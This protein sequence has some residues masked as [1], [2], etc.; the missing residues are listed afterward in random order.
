VA[1]RTDP[2]IGWALAALGLSIVGGF[3]LRAPALLGSLPSGAGARLA[4]E[5]VVTGALGASILLSFMSAV[6]IITGSGALGGLAL[7][8]GTCILGIAYVLAVFVPMF[9]ADVTKDRPVPDDLACRRLAPVVSWWV[10]DE[11]AFDRD[12]ARLEPGA[13]TRLA[14]RR[15]QEIEAW[16]ERFRLLELPERLH[17]PAQTVDAAVTALL[18]AWEAQRFSP[19]GTSTAAVA[20]ERTKALGAIR[21]LGAA[22]V[23]EGATGSAP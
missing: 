20:T 17:D 19:T 21:A 1:R 4:V 5:V 2:L 6:R 23:D 12:L 8:V 18:A 22:C 7:A 16:L 13:A 15:T 3:A 14:A 11:A 9:M 10:S